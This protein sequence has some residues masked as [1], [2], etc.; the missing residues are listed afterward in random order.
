MSDLLTTTEAAAVLGVPTR[1]LTRMACAGVIA[2]DRKL[3]GRNG[4]LLWDRDEVER[5]AA[6]RT[7]A[8]S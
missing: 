5:V 7:G 4:S 3:P 8:K 1:R 6:E 2:Y